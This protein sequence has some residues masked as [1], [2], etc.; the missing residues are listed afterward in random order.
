M[1][2]V[3]GELYILSRTE[4]RVGQAIVLEGSRPVL[5]ELV[6]QGRFLAIRGFSVDEEEGGEL[7]RW[8]RGSFSVPHAAA[9]WED[10]TGDSVAAYELL[11]GRI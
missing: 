7:T 9:F 8:R 6:R 2:A 1:S 3:I 4:E 5:L 10:L 11:R